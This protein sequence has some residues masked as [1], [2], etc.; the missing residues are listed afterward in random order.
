M[1]YLV[2]EIIALIALAFAI[3][4][5]I[6]WLWR[7]LS[8]NSQVESTKIEL[9]QA[10][11]KKLT[12]IDT[13]LD[14]AKAKS[15]EYE[16]S[17][18][19]AN[20]KLEQVAKQAQQF[21][22]QGDQFSTQIVNLTNTNNAYK[23]QIAQLQSNLSTIDTKHSGEVVAL[24]NRLQQAEEEASK[25]KQETEAIKA[26]AQKE[27]DKVVKQ[28]QQD[29][30]KEV[31]QAQLEAKKA[32]D[33]AAKQARDKA[34]KLAQEAQDEAEK[35]AKE[36]RARAEQSARDAQA[37]AQQIA[38]AAQAQAEQ[39]AKQAQEA[40]QK[41]KL[42]PVKRVSNAYRVDEI[43]GIGK[44]YRKKLE[45]VGV[46]TTDD[47]LNKAGKNIDERIKI[48]EHL[49]TKLTVVTSWVAMADLLRIEG[50]DGQ[51]AEILNAA[52][53]KTVQEL[54]NRNTDALFNDILRI[55]DEQRLVPEL[56]SKQDFA[57][58]VTKAREMEAVLA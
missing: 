41:A 13:Q 2:L 23:Q 46:K 8:V 11:N 7:G 45:E 58:W 17:L 34:A 51:S 21:Q 15:A 4:A 39:A 54:S 3:G 19:E 20:I 9:E 14:N 6:G 42:Q 1:T 57:G 37:K 28:I 53:V 38:Q 43:E 18:A 10:S 26:Q 56:A 32:A 47:L 50:L 35:A 44:T 48:S 31:E 27:V 33:R 25:S 22:L 5:F 24:K 55:N 30:Q 40:V 29:A 52:G 49:N 36:A 12:E 16:A